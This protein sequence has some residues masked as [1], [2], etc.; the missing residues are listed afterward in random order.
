MKNEHFTLSWALPRPNLIYISHITNFIVV[1]AAAAAAASQARQTRKLA[2]EF[3]A[4]L[5]ASQKC[6]FLLKLFV[7]F[8]SARSRGPGYVRSQ[9]I[10]FCFYNNLVN[11]DS[12]SC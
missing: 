5:Q 4:S 2:C 1:V 9:T 10:L 6:K 11:E 8:L 3:L 12:S 7:F